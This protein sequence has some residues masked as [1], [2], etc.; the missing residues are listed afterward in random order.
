MGF[1]ETFIDK[2]YNVYEKDILEKDLTFAFNNI[3]IK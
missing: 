3:C 2:N 1:G